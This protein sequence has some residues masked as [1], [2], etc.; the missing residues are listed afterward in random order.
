[1]KDISFSSNGK[2]FEE[3]E[4]LKQV[5]RDEIYNK[6]RNLSQSPSLQFYERSEPSHNKALQRTSR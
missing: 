4:R 1:M 6:S 2:I 3:V 5:I